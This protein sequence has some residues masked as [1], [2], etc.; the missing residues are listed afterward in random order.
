MKYV[1]SAA[2]LLQWLAEAHYSS[3]RA[4]S[5]SDINYFCITGPHL[6]I[7]VVYAGNAHSSLGRLSRAIS[8]KT[9]PLPI[10]SKAMSPPRLPSSTLQPKQ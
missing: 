2:P 1:S 7:S 9:K 6:G 8:H 4:S 10:L 5:C 3:S